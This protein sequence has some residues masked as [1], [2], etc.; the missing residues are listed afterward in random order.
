MEVHSD[1]SG[2]ELTYR[3]VRD[4]TQKVLIYAMMYVILPMLKFLKN[5]LINYLLRYFSA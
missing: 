1:V 4:E 3:P 5:A 2:L